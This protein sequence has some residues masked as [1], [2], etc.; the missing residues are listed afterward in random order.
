MYVFLWS[1]FVG[2]VGGW[3]FLEAIALM[4]RTIA[5]KPSGIGDMTD[6]N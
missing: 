6:L 5:A 2:V 1:G 3:L 4:R